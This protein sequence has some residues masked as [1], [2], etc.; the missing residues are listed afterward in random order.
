MSVMSNQSFPMNGVKEGGNNCVKGISPCRCPTEQQGRLGRYRA[1]AKGDRKRKWSQE[2]NR[3]V[4]EC[5][6][7]SNPKVVR[8][9]E[10]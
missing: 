3:F 1:T 2:V 7:S 9:I 10:R 4:M 6:Y 8:Y 5:Y